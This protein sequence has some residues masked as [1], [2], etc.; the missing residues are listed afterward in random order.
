MLKRLGIC[1]TR[2]EWNGERAL[3][4][5]R[6][7]FSERRDLRRHPRDDLEPAAGLGSILTWSRIWVGVD[8]LPALGVW[9]RPRWRQGQALRVAAGGLRPALTPSSGRHRSRKPPEAGPGFKIKRESRGNV[10]EGFV[11]G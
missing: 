11:R 1:Y 2:P 10:V 6:N 9:R 3:R 8:L 4:L 7:W 5:L